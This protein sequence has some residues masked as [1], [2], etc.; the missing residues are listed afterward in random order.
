MAAQE[1]PFHETASPASLPGSSIPPSTPK[2]TTFG[3]AGA[4]GLNRTIS[5]FG[6]TGDEMQKHEEEQKSFGEKRET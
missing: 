3:G 1:F 2:H 4:A 6:V 5:V